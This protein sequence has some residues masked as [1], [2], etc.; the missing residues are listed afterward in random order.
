MTLRGRS[1][2]ALAAAVALLVVLA[3]SAAAAGPSITYS[4]TSGTAGDNG[5]Y[6]S[7][8]TAQITVTGATDTTCPAV[9]TFRSNSD[10]FDCTAKDNSSTIS[11]HL[12]FKIDKDAPTVTAAQPD[13]AAN[14]NGWFTAPVTVAFSGTDATSG[15]ASCSTVPYGGPDNGAAS[16][17]GTC[18]DVAGNVSAESTFP[19]KYDAT[20]P[21]LEN[22]KAVTGNRRAVVEWSASPDVS[23][24][25]VQRTRAA[26]G[27][28]A[29]SCT[30]ARRAA[31]P[32]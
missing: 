2:A 24:V 1:G 9:K 7:D 29:P 4:I 12:Q 30:R 14:A 8:V 21:K 18:R 3:P 10:V 20:P 27:R 15:I 16:V 25:V 22:V 32:T 6:R 26:P 13:R 5:W 19:L 23:Q 31:S 28:R 17:P 11:F